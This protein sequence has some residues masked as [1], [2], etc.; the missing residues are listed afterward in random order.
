MY[1]CGQSVEQLIERHRFFLYYI[2]DYTSSDFNLDL[3]LCIMKML[4]WCDSKTIYSSIKCNSF[5]IIQ[6][7]IYRGT[8]RI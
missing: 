2:F 1:V 3:L 5:D 7:S 8:P 6:L 4:L